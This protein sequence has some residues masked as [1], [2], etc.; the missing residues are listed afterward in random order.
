MQKDCIFCKIVAGEIPSE[1]VLETEHCIVI[2]DINPQAPIHLLVI[3]KE[4][5]HDI[6][7]LDDKEVAADIIHAINETAKK[8]DLKDFRVVNNRGPGA[9]QSVFHVHFHILAGRPFAWPP[10]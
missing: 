2:K 3:T 1:K 8:L 7:H 9:G 5:Y 10:G 4:H 6:T